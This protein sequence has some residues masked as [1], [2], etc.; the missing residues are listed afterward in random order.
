MFWLEEIVDVITSCPANSPHVLPIDFSWRILKKLARRM[1]RETL[2]EQKSGLRGTWSLIPQDTVDRLY[3]AFQTIL[4][5]CLVNHRES[6]SNQLRQVTERHAL[7]SFP[8][9]NTVHVR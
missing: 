2:Q 5:L 4:Q 9:A 1:K 8:E 6:I 3:K 7:K